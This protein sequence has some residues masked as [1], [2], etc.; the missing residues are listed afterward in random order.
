MAVKKK[1][2]YDEGSIKALT[3][4][5]GVR[6]KPGM[7]LSER[8]PQ[9]VFR[10]VKEVADNVYD[11]MLAGRN[12][13]L[14]LFIDT[15]NN[16]YILA[17]KAEG[18]PVGINKETK[19]STLEA[20]MTILHAGG[21][22]DDD[23]SYEAS[24]GTHG[25]GVSCVNAVSEKFEVWTFRDGKCYTQSYAKGEPTSKVAV[26]KV[27]K[28]VQTKLGYLPKQGTIIRFFPDQEIVSVDKGKTVA[29]LDV[30]Y[31]VDWLKNMSDMNKG[32]EIVVHCN[33]KTKTFKNKDGLINRIKARMA[34]LDV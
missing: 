7:Y 9:M 12:N 22:L 30:A 34:E 19:L 5:K 24:A 3:G 28:D 21:K 10:M 11:E 26:G 8:G 16:E 31:T 33:G 25:V 15:K 4:L 20:V 6:A 1:P 32:F 27:P 17:D 14:C 23:S 18:I 13:F 2:A 29:K